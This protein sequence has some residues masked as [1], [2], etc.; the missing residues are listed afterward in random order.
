MS[1]ISNTTR[2]TLRSKRAKQKDAL[3]ESESEEEQLQQSILK[4]SKPPKRKSYSPALSESEDEVPHR[5]KK[6][7]PVQINFVESE[8]EDEDGVVKRPVRARRLVLELSDNSAEGSG[9]ASEN[10]QPHSRGRLHRRSSSIPATRPTR[11]SRQDRD[12]LKEELEFLQSLF[13]DPRTCSS[14]LTVSQG[15]DSPS[16]GRRAGHEREKRLRAMEALKRRRAKQAGTDSATRT[17]HRIVVIEDDED[18]EGEQRSEEENE[19]DDYDGINEENIPEASIFRADDYDDDFVVEDETL[20]AP[21]EL[22]LEFSNFRTMKAQDLFKYAVEWMVQKKINPAF[23]MEDDVYRIAFDRLDDF[24]KG[25]GGSKFLSSAWTSDFSK[26]LKARPVLQDHRF[27]NTGLEHNRCDACNRSGHPATFEVRFTGNTYDRV[28][29]EE[30]SDDDSDVE[31][32]SSSSVPSVD[33]IYY[34]GKWVGPGGRIEVIADIYQILH[35]QR[36]HS[37]RAVPLALSFERVGGGL[38]ERGGVSHGE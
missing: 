4:K 1:S 35:G 15:A 24:V 26:S 9:S 13:H 32:V 11:I 22:P 30:D 36:T 27:M 20:G 28:S 14:W 5:C 8:D 19:Q 6:S 21:V 33:V 18:D 16:T 34:I 12:D 23:A 25:L 10:E 37:T 3:E 29:L 38:S 17:S 31:R 2:E 7:R